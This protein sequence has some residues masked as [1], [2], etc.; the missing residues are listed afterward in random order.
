MEFYARFLLDFSI[1]L[2]LL[3]YNFA[4]PVR[5]DHCFATSTVGFIYCGNH[6]KLP[7]SRIYPSAWDCDL[8]DLL[9]GKLLRL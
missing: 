7:K 8:D 2:A 6:A 1:V 4:L 3:W 5:T 9:K